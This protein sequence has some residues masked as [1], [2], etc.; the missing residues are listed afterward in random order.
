M[1]LFK[2]ILTLSLI[3]IF[4]S[5]CG[6]GLQTSK[7]T[8]STSGSKDTNQ[9]RPIDSQI[10]PTLSIKQ[11]KS[12]ITFTFSLA[13]HTSHIKT[14]HFNTSQTY[15]YTIKNQH[16]KTIRRYSKGRMFAQHTS[17]V[18]VKK[19]A[20]LSFNGT[21][22]DLPKGGYT[23][24]IWLT[25]NKEHPK[26]SQQFTVTSQSEQ[27]STSNRPVTPIK[28]KQSNTKTQEGI[29]AG[30]MKPSLSI[31]QLNG[32]IDFTFSIKNQTEHIVTYSFNTSQ[33]YEYLIKNA[34]GEIVKQYSKGRMFAMHTSSVQVK[35]GESL[36]YHDQV[37]DL[38]KGS[39]TMTIW[40][41]ANEG[42]PKVSQ[43]FEIH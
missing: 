25:A 12:D 27:K 13:N 31:Q 28:G 1:K 38:P 8:G 16:G 7:A 37:E 24:T 3:L 29:V 17:T 22:K 23:M 14:Y 15:D 33:T 10:V 42:H 26:V 34:N 35:Q 43:S 30:E 6:Q 19:G 2:Y 36:T 21:I 32:G 20:S 39:Y 4:A 11:N 9:G 40:L 5:G 41:T 18:H